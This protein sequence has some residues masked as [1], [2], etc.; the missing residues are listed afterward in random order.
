MGD[1]VRMRHEAARPSRLGPFSCRST[2]ATELSDLA[3]DVVVRP[4]AARA[5][6]LGVAFR[7]GGNWRADLGAAGTLG[8][9]RA[10]GVDTP[11]DLAS[12]TKPLVAVSAA[13]LVESGLLGFD[14]KLGEL[15]PAIQDS[16]SANVSLALALAHR[17]G[18]E[19]HRDLVAAWRGGGHVARRRMLVEAARGR[20]AGAERAPDG[21]YP[22]VYSDLGYVLVGEAL[23][24][25]SKRPLDEV[26][27]EW[28]A[29]PL[30]L[31][32]GSARS[33]WTRR[34]AMDTGR[35]ALAAPTEVSRGT[36]RPLSWRVHDENAWGLDGYGMS[37]HAG[38]FGTASAVL[39][40]G[41]AVL[42]ALLGESAFLTQS[43][44]ELLVRR[45][46]GGDLAMGFDRKSASGS[47]AGRLASSEAFG[48]LGFTG[49][50][51][52]CDPG[53][54]IVVTLLTNRVC[55]WGSDER[56]RNVRPLVHDR[57]QAYALARAGPSAAKEPS[58]G[59]EP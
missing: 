51:L 29:D 23:A 18:L 48:H 5:A 1:K 4:G 42:D 57:L 13:R 36:S 52:W 35:Y 20:R 10:A 9:G 19:A 27:A 32:L 47:S 34:S 7:E 38:A 8:G 25:L 56:I 50:S 3:R 28:V 40:F 44:A 24:L 15:V 43:S 59:R 16:P 12:L 53:S 6:A 22:P 30:G 26:V 41:A 11:Y 46:A 54:G 37:G 45:R 33:W 58:A 14:A 2:D 39:G 17:A 21:A 49:T 55:P 31:E